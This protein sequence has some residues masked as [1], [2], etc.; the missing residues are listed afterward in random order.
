M[1]QEVTFEGTLVFDPIDRTAKHKKQSSWKKVAMVVIDGEI[2]PNKRIKGDTW[3][4]YAWFLKKRYNIILN[5]PLRGTHISFI[6]DR[7]GDLNGGKGTREERE[8]MWNQLKK[9]YHHTK[10]QVTLSTDVRSDG[11]HWWL[12][13]PEEDRTELHKIRSEVGL[14]RPFYGLHMSIGYAVDGRTNEDIE[15]HAPKAGRMDLTTSKMV[16]ELL[17]KGLYK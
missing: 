1:K 15:D 3:G 12:V 9:K 4:L 7:E 13:M 16:H 8:H 10:I 2:A 5:P 14:G 11:N 6:N 17:K